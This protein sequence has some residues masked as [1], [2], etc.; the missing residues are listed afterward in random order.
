MWHQIEYVAQQ[1]NVDHTALRKFA[2]DNKDKYGIVQ[3]ATS[4]EVN[5]W[6][7]DKLVEDLKKSYATKKVDVQI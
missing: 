3:N 5:T 6:H 1:R 2:L 7:V 4:I